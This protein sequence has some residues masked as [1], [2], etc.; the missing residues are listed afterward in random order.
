MSRN[1]NVKKIF[2]N[3]CF[4][5]RGI[6][7]TAFTLC[8]RRLE[9][10]AR[11]VPR[12]PAFRALTCRL[13]TRRFVCTLK[14]RP[15]IWRWYDGYDTSHRPVV[16]YCTCHVVLTGQKKPNKKCCEFFIGRVLAACGGIHNTT[17]H[18]FHSHVGSR[19]LGKGWTVFVAPP[20]KI[21]IAR[22]MGSSTLTGT[23][24]VDADCQ[25]LTWPT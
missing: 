19:H 4:T 10:S 25:A 11:Y 15:V 18:S 5:L 17:F 12:V 9:E 22:L 8:L 21:W 14:I 1:F 16:P 7:C 2:V 3:A 20:I 13:F 23:G 24:S 6:L